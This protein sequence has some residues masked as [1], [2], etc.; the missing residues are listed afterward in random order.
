MAVDLR[1]QIFAGRAERRFTAVV[2]AGR[3]GVLAGVAAAETQAGPIGLRL[4]WGYA[5]GDRLAAD[6]P[7]VTVTG[8][9]A[10]IAMGEERLLGCLCKPSGIA[11]AA[12]RAVDLASGRVRV[13][14][15]AWKKMP[16]ELKEPVRRAVA[17]G[18]M[19]SRI[20]DTPFIYLDKNYIRM[21][22]GITATLQAVQALDGVKVIQVRGEE[23]PVSVETERAWRH[24]AGVVMVDTGNGDD[25]RAALDVASG[26][27]GL[28]IA[29]AG[30]IRLDDIPGLAGTG[31]S[32]LD[33]GTAIVDAPL[34]DMK[35]DV[36]GDA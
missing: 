1:H 35:F 11:T 20:L 27:P 34:L 7:V 36:I 4:T 18:G 32:I 23:A 30:G 28:Q 33:I 29:F 16:P 9:P 13:V 31:V 26:C 25:L 6:T 22:G 12:R 21:F 17:A 24:G 19:P 2:S 5:E 8:G 15:G 14:S 10:A 3:A